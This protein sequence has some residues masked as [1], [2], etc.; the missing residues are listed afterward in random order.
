[1]RRISECVCLIFVRANE[2]WLRAV[3]NTDKNKNCVFPANKPDN[4]TCHQ[5]K[6]AHFANNFE[7]IVHFEKSF[8]I[9]KLLFK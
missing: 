5:L 8:K 7:N 1:M 9:Q 4:E 6:S 3:E 2:L